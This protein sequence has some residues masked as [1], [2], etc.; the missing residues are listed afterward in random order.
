MDRGLLLSL[1]AVLSG[2]ALILLALLILKPVISPS[3][4]ELGWA[5]LYVLLGFL[6]MAAALLLWYG[7]IKAIFL[8]LKVV[9]PGGLEPPTSRFSSGDCSGSRH[10]RQALY[11]V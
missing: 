6:S 4:K 3:S 5:V 9:G 8:R 10:I 2:W 1:Y 7:S 11:P